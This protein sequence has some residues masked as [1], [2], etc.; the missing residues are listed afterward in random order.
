[1]SISYANDEAPVIY[2]KTPVTLVGLILVNAV[3]A[4]LIL[5]SWRLVGLFVSEPLSWATWVPV[6]RGSGYED[7]VRYPFVVLWLWPLIGIVGAWVS[8]KMTKFQLAFAFASMPI[9]VLGLVIGWFYL[10]PQDWH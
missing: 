10:T 8:L 5:F 7:I 4:F 2:K 3:F 6:Y 9:V 1:M